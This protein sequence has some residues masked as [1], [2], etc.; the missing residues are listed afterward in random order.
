MRN[1]K[2][3]EKINATRNK[4]ANA[5]LT[6]VVDTKDDREFFRFEGGK[7]VEYECTKYYGFPVRLTQ[8]EK[9]AS[10]YPL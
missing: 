7:L 3:Q 2:D 4:S 5:H 8:E 1:Q 10:N 9:T 6:C